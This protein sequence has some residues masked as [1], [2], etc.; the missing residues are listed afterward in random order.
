MDL[1][2]DKSHIWHPYASLGTS[3]R[4]AVGGEGTEIVLES[5]KRLVDAVS[6]WWC[7]THGYNH[8]HIVEAI[9]KQSEKLSHIMFGGFTHE[10]A[11]E[12]AS[13]ICKITPQG[14]NKIFF[15]D[16]GSISVEVAAK[17]A[18]QYQKAKGHPERCKLLALKGGYHGD[19]SLAMALSDPDGMHTLFR[20]IMTHHYFAEKPSISFW[21]EWSKEEEFSLEQIISTKSDCIAAVIC[22]PI[23]QAANAMN[24]YNTEYLK[25]LRRV[26]DKYGI[27]LIFDEIAAGFYRLGPLWA[28]SYAS[29]TPDIMTIGKSLTGGHISLAATI[30]SD[31]VADVI[32]SGNPSAFMHGPTYMANPIACAAANASLE[33][34]ENSDYQAKVASIE[35]KFSNTIFV[36][37]DFDN[38]NR[39]CVLGAT[40]IIEVNSMPERKYI[41]K[42]IDK[43]G[44]WL[45][46]FSNYI[47]SF[48]PL[49]STKEDV[50]KIAEA[51]V[52]LA[53]CPPGPILEEEF[54]E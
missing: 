10:P 23:L 21:E 25:T 5:G 22:E 49:V 33:L 39:V 11:I 9:K 29:V 31:D 20:G 19:T 4:G 30:V 51:M 7:V 53:Q 8:P 2:F 16:S 48:P 27:L 6:S 46:P 54:H 24:V 26:C 28:Q 15:A 3:V 43:T 13:R 37:K 41:D 34:F 44:V 12:L 35:E 32:S 18:I 38:V 40:A 17:M 45:R 1:A 52:E 47:Y 36:A 42:V 50:K 14:L